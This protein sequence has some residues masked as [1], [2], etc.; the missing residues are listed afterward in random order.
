MKLPKFWEPRTVCQPE[1]ETLKTRGFGGRRSH[2][3]RA[4]ALFLA[5]ALTPFPD[6]HTP[7]SPHFSLWGH[8]SRAGGGARAHTHAHVHTRTR[9]CTDS[10]AQTLSFAH[11]LSPVLTP[12]LFPSRTLACARARALF[13]GLF[14]T[15][16]TFLG[17]AL[18]ILGSVA[19]AVRLVM[20]DFLLSG[21]DFMRGL[22]G[23]L[24]L[25]SVA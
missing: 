19:E 24:V 22:V 10:L 18:A 23:G 13:L 7:L 17:L 21:Q 6:H 9:A 11:T 3:P 25:C 16:I 14:H 8:V 12:T 15:S 2:A 5:R 1:N 4:L 20:T